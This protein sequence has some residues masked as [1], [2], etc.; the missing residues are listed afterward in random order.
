M[1]TPAFKT[2]GIVRSSERWFS[3]DKCKLLLKSH[4][5]YKDHMAYDTCAICNTC[6]PT[7]ISLLKHRM[8][9]HGNEMPENSVKINSQVIKPRINSKLKQKYHHLGPALLKQVLEN[10]T[11]DESEERD[12]QCM[13]CVSDVRHEKTYLKF[14]VVVI[15]KEGWARVSVPILLLA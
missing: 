3:C 8:K 12:Y 1:S 15:P 10:K 13:Q 11:S 4:V 14:F 9:Y 7:R 2:S 5:H 6:F